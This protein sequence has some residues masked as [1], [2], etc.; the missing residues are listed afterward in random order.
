MGDGGGED[1]RR[2]ITGTLLEQKQRGFV[3]HYRLAP[4]CGPAL[5]EAALALV[6]PE[7]QRFQVLEAAMAWE[8]RPRG[9][10]KGVA[11]AALAAEAPFAGRRPIFIGDDVT[12]ED[13]MRAAPRAGAAPGCA[14]MPRSARPRRSATGCGAAPTS[15][16][17]GLGAMGQSDDVQRSSGTIWRRAVRS[18]KEQR[19]PLRGRCDVLWPRKTRVGLL[20]LVA[21]VTLAVPCRTR[22]ADDAGSG[23]AVEIAAA[24]CLTGDEQ[25][26]GKSSLEGM[27]L[28]IAEANDSS[29][30]PRI[31]LRPYDE[32]STVEGGQRIAQQIADSPASR[33]SGRCSASSPW[34]R[35]PSSRAAASPRWRRRPRT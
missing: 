16:T 9:V 29:V 33:C 21:F 14:S 7:G 6:A 34:S 2:G 18:A 10:D 17:S 22:A 27:E 26:L 4:E 32:Q 30:G 12:D 1:R 35:A 8:V 23:N 11:V 15:S 19:S 3:L 5:R 28:A 31:V 20:T 24:L 25:Q 13:G